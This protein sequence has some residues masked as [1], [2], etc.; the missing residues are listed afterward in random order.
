MTHALD[1]AAGPARQASGFPSPAADYE[2]SRIDLN[3]LL[4]PAPLSTFLM[5][6]C[7]DAMRGDG[8]R[9]GDLLVIDRTLTPRPGCVVVAVHEG[10][11][12]VRR[13]RLGPSNR[14]PPRLEASDGKNAPIPLTDG[15]GG[16]ADVWG[17][18]THAVR[19]LVRTQAG[20]RREP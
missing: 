4:V 11:F 17:V 12:I 1:T 9:D 6:V 16:G 3:R 5:R 7:G 14:H 15:Q 2:E 10:Q 19:H 8:I 18:V 20:E 13:L